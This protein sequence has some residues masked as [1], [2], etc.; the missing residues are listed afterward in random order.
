MYDVF[1]LAPQTLLGADLLASLS[2]ALVLVP[3]FFEGSPINGDWFPADTD[4]KRAAVQ[5]WVAGTGDSDR[6]RE[7]LLRVRREVGEKWPAVEGHVGVFGLC[8]GGK[9][10]SRPRCPTTRLHGAPCG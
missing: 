4:E 2:G 5:A 6:S 9:R 8:W 1:G 10:K 7:K 3:D